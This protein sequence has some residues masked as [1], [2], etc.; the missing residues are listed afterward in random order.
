MSSNF[1]NNFLF[2]VNGS[3]VSGVQL[4]VTYARRQIAIEPINGATSSSTWCTIGTMI[5]KIKFLLIF[6]M[7]KVSKLFILIY[8]LELVQYWSITYMFCGSY[9]ICLLL[10]HILRVSLIMKAL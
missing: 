2:Q 1:E 8:L 5:S 7:E 3:L 10:F 9:F 4:K 6:L